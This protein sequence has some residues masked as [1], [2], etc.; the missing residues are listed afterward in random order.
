MSDGVLHDFV[1]N[2]D[3]LG[4]SAWRCHMPAPPVPRGAVF[5]AFVAHVPPFCPGCGQN[6]EAIEWAARDY[7]GHGDLVPRR[8]KEDC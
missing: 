5:H 7:G 3:D 8:K 4:R 2:T 6:T 1:R